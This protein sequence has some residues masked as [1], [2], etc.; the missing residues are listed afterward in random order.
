[1]RHSNILRG[2]SEATRALLDLK[3]QEDAIQAAVSALGA[4]TDVDRCYIFQIEGNV[5][6]RLISQ[7][8]EWVKGSVSVQINNERLQNM[9]EALFPWLMEKLDQDEILYGIVSHSD[10]PEF[11]EGMAEQDIK[12]Y[13][14]TPIQ[15]DG[16]LWGFIG[17]DDCVEERDW[18]QVEAD[19]LAT[20]AKNIG[21]RLAWDAT[22]KNLEERNEIFELAVQGAKLGLWEWL[23]ET[24]KVY[25]SQAYAGILGYS[26]EALTDYSAWFDNIHEE[27]RQYVLDNLQAHLSDGN[28]PYDVQYRTRVGSGEF[29]WVASNGMA[30]R[31]SNNR[32]IILTGFLRDI[33]EQVVAQEARNQAIQRMLELNELKSNFVSMASHQF[34]TPLTVIYS[35]VEL[36]EM[37]I[38]KLEPSLMQRFSKATGRIKDEVVRM[39][40]L[41]NNI[42]T[43]G[44]YEAGLMTIRF[45]SMDVVQLIKRINEQY[46]SQESDGRRIEI[47][48]EGTPRLL[49][50]D[51]MLLTHAFSNLMSNALKYSPQRP[52]PQIQIRFLK[53]V[54]QVEIRDYGIGI[55]EK[56]QPNTFNSFFRASNASTIV[57]S[58]LGLPIVKEFLERHKGSVTFNSI[59]NKGSTFTVQLPYEQIQNTDC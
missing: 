35:N 52:A 43:F 6:E 18:M 41:M 2:I 44:K 37:G 27:D 20:V 7:R 54:L 4:G 48:V 45:A 28:K 22:K 42:L 40:E 55:P 33:H 53:D 59:E 5:G 57:G 32:P 30:K 51:S 24:N 13:L 58:G 34:R 19:A 46:F 23:P 14:F 29:R 38:M 8:F 36:M 11:K 21:I 56:D 15:K 17:Y 10:D 26:V 31:D 49:T 16:K 3:V 47:L 39:T 12:S 1:M 9:P 50:A 25:P